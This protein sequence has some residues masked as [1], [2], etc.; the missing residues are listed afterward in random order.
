MLRMRFSFAFLAAALALSTGSQVPLAHAADPAPAAAKPDYEAARR[1][2]QAAKAAEQAGRTD[3]AVR[4]YTA[5]Y[6][7]TKDAKILYSIARVYEAGGDNAKAVAFYRRYL[8]ENPQAK[9]A[10]MVKAHIAELERRPATATPPPPTPTPT[11][12]PTPTTP[13]PPGPPPAPPPDAPPT[14]PIEEDAPPV[15]G[16]EPTFLDEGPRWQRTAA[17]V[18]VGLAAVALTTGAVLAESA[19]SRAEDMERLQQFRDPQT[20]LPA[21]YAGNVE[22]AYEDARSEGERLQTYSRAVFI[23]AG[24]FTVA[25]IVFFILDPGPGQVPTDVGQPRRS[26]DLVI[27]PVVDEHS[28][29]VAASWGF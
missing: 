3:E 14:P 4:E 13:P 22:A 19:S 2:Y 23:G 21:P 28:F 15:D 5:A 24:V 18:S 16:I 6:D 25:A 1:H 11:P 27:A 29:G 26:R 12:P 10:D 7:I 9:D 17:W 20:Q 8:L